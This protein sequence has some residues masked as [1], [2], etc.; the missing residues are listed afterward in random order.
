MVE[1]ESMTRARRLIAVGVIVLFGGLSVAWAGSGLDAKAADYFTAR[2]SEI[3]Y[4]KTDTI[5]N[6]SAAK[7]GTSESL[8]LTCA[9][10]IRDP[11]LVL[12]TLAQGVVT[13]LT[14]RA[15]QDLN[16]SPLSL[17]AGPPY[18]R[19]RYER[20][21][22]P[23]P[24]EPRWRAMV[25]SALRLSPNQTPVPKLVSELQP[26]PMILQLDTRTLDQAGGQLHQVKGYFHALVAESLENVDV[27]FEPNDQWVR[28]T[29]SLEIQLRQASCTVSSFQYRIE[30]R[31]QNEYSAPLRL[32]DPLPGRLVVARQLLGP[33]GKPRDAYSG[34]PP[35]LPAHISGGMSGGGTDCQIKAIRFVIAVNPAHCRIPF[36]FQH[37]PLPDPNQPPARHQPSK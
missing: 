22:M 26:S 15:G 4:T 6:A 7:Q 12:G 9:I 37:V 1:G 18:E 30:T 23:P 36:E 5:Q 16:V 14:G 13:Q 19:P 28:L 10:T 25:R 32:G 3:A 8:S 33:D 29:P 2:W 35:W 20:R 11:N 21:Y 17:H 27:P 31:P 34:Q 24:K